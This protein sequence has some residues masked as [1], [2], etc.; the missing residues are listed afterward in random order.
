ML[1]EH[2]I[3]R[4]IAYADVFEYPL[5]AD[6]L[7][8]FLITSQKT[9]GNAFK[10]AI[11]GLLKKKHIVMVNNLYCLPQHKKYAAQRHTRQQHVSHK[12]DIARRAVRLL[13]YIPTVFFI[14]VS[15]ALSMENAPED[16]DIDFFIITAA[17]SLWIT[18]LLC[19]CILDFFR[20]RRKPKTLNVSNKICLNMFMEVSDLA[21]GDPERDLYSAHEVAQVKPLLNKYHTYEHFLAVNKWVLNLLPNA[22][23]LTKKQKSYSPKSVWVLEKLN[24]LCKQIQ[25]RYMKKRRTLEVISDSVARFHPKDARSW[26]LKEYEK[27]LR[28]LSK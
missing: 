3:L 14:G 15:G 11:S 20:L 25:L 10:K 1:I 21:I 18:R 13:S 26:V 6:E 16:D 7:W 23:V 5:H 12:M 2:A 9:S 24:V 22:F 27:R 17:N 4:T 28:A 8:R 19:V